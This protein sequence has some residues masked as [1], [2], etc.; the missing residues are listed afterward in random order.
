MYLLCVICIDE[1]YVYLPPPR[2]LCNAQRLSVCLSFSNITSKP[3]NRSSSKFYHKCASRSGSMNFLK[4]S[5]TLRDDI[6]PQFGSYKCNFEQGN[7]AKFWKSSGSEVNP[8]PDS[9][10][11]PDSPWRRYMRS[12][13]ALVCDVKIYFRYMLA[14]CCIVICTQCNSICL[15]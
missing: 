10:Y 3:L 14:L 1:N 5:S 12:L 11:R 8:Y 6:F 9:G 13:T 7:P 2:R 4:D 15:H